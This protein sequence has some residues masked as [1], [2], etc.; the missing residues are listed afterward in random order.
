MLGTEVNATQPQLQLP[1]KPRGC[2]LAATEWSVMEQLSRAAGWRAQALTTWAL[3]LPLLVTASSAEVAGAH[4]CACRCPGI[5]KPPRYQPQIKWTAD[6][7]SN[8]DSTYYASGMGADADDDIDFQDGRARQAVGSTSVFSQDCMLKA[9]PGQKGTQGDQG[10]RGMP[11][12][13]G[14]P[15]RHGSPGSR[16]PVGEPGTH[17][18]EGPPG[19][20]GR[21]GSEG[22]QGL[23][24]PRGLPGEAGPAG[25]RGLPGT[26]QQRVAFQVRLQ[27]HVGPTPHAT[28][29]SFDLVQTNEGGG[30]D[31]A[32]SIFTGP[33]TGVYVFHL[34]VM[35]HDGYLAWVALRHNGQPVAYAWANGRPDSGSGSEV[36]GVT[37]AVLQLRAGD[38]V[39]VALMPS[40]DP[41]NYL[42]AH[43]TTLFG[44]M[45]FEA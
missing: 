3:L 16:G 18:D 14:M 17:G 41:S 13:P 21:R 45:L 30:F 25:P 43:Y 38:V 27:D 1:S 8:F 39:D 29:L 32:R 19:P 9:S 11:G 35:A 42:Y 31:M 40:A 5:I 15:G 4:E 24:G 44:Y 26:R 6:E 34:H 7:K 2:Q 23:P 22:M 37:A 12:D 28:R 33:H 36:M 10:A 20:P